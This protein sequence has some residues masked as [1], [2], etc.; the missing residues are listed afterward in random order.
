MDCSLPGSSVHGIFQAIVLEWIA[1]SFSRGSSRPR[2]RTWVSRI[3]DR[4]FTVW[5]TREVK[6]L[7]D[8]PLKCGLWLYSFLCFIED[9]LL[10]LYLFC[11]FLVGCEGVEKSKNVATLSSLT[12]IHSQSDF[13]LFDIFSW[14]SLR[15]IK[16]SMLKNENIF[17]VP[18]L[19]PFL[20]FPTSGR[21]IIIPSCF[22]SGTVDVF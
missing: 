10:S 11:L 14:T 12:K 4:C 3:V 13:K 20:V 16:I 6:Y 19:F 1:I 5:A 8:M 17:L 21:G 9:R 7:A 22:D 15:N 2:D 18:Q